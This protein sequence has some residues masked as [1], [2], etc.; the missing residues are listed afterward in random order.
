MTHNTE[1]LP[2]IAGKIRALEK[3]TIA[4]I[5]ESGRLLQIAFD[6]FEHGDRAAYHQ[7]IETEIGLSERQV[8]RYRNVFEFSQICQFGKNAFGKRKIADLN[9]SKSALYMLVDNQDLWPA[10]IIK[11]VLKLAS[12][13]RVMP[14]QVDAVYAKYRAARKPEPEQPEP[15]AGTG[16]DADAGTGHAAEPEQAAE[17]DGDDAEAEHDAEADG[18][19]TEPEPEVGDDTPPASNEL[20]DA[21]QIV[22]AH[23]VYSTAW[24]VATKLVDAVELQSIIDTL[25]AVYAKHYG[26]D[27]VKRKANLAEAQ[28]KAKIKREGAML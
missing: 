2:V 16:D 27:D 5:I 7:W 24:D 25:Q 11:E 17:I 12:K 1:S 21:L 22:S 4:N 9:I 13:T 26:H 8:D 20:S 28:S 23:Y 14:A 19:G 6:S 18:D 15:D 10:E 3:K